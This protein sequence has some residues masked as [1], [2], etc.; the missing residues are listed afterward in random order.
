MVTLIMKDL[1]GINL[2]AIY[3][4]VEV[5]LESSSSLLFLPILIEYFSTKIILRIFEVFGTLCILGKK[6]N[7]YCYCFYWFA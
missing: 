3:M 1:F 2:D 5:P 6:F 4:F 7:D